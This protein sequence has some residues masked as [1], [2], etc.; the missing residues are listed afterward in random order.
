MVMFFYLLFLGEPDTLFLFD[1]PENSFHTRWKRTF[2]DTLLE[3]GKKY[4]YY[5]IITTHSSTLL[6]QY[7]NLA[8][9]LED[10]YEGY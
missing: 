4:D 9:N 10:Q 1:E 6:S 5:F 8:T 7:F 3:I 2:I